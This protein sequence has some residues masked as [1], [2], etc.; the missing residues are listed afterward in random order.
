MALALLNKDKHTR[1]LQIS[2]NS[3]GNSKSQ[4]LLVETNDPLFIQKG[5]LPRTNSM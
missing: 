5:I 2:G 1:K 3:N 4:T